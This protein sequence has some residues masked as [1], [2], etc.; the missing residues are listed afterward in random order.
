M[1]P[2]ENY[3]PFV[4]AGFVLTLAILISFQAYLFGEPARIMAVE[5]ADRVAAEVAGRAMYLDNCT[6]CHG[7]NGEGKVGP[8]L[9]SREHLKTTSDDTL[10]SLTRTGVPGTIMPAW[11]QA[12]GG[13]F[14]DEQVRQMVAFI[15]A[16]EPTAPEI[17]PVSTEPD[18]VRGA[19][20][21]ATNCF[22]CH[23]ENGQGT[24]RAPKLNDPA[25]LDDFPPAWYRST[26][27]FGRPA[28][29]MPTWG[30]V[31]SP[32]QIGDLVA[33]LMAWRDGQVVQPAI[34]LSKHLSSALFALQQFDPVD[35]EFHLTAALDRATGAQAADIQAALDLIRAKDRAGAEARLL[36]LLPPE[37]V[38]QEV[39]AAYC[40]SCHA[41]D[42]TGGIGKNLRDNAFIQSKSDTELID[43][44]LTGR[45]GTAMD[46]FEGI[47]APEQLSSVIAL[48]RTWQK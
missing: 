30:T 21:F 3:A 38:G 47:L 12:F 11:G 41:P 39:Y 26:I 29:G 45:P 33:L 20:I 36:A 9:N 35:A 34:P 44:V 25:R 17:K 14:T 15:R 40:A 23:G 37:E 43:F 2:R 18:P 19:T 27:S 4:A 22:I 13:P 1:R 32:R 10:F 48:F 31:L 7:E 5:A 24:D 28:K 8:A 46:G 16:W 42:G 6:A